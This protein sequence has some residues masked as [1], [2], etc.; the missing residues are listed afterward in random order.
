[1]RPEQ[2]RQPQPQ[3]KVAKGALIGAAAVLAVIYSAGRGGVA[4]NP[5][6]LAFG[7]RPVGDSTP[8]QQVL[9]QNTSP[10]PLRISSVTVDGANSGDFL[11]AQHDCIGAV[12]ESGNSCAIDVRFLPQ[13]SGDRNAMLVL[14]DN[15][16]DSP[17]TVRL[18]GSATDRR[19]LVLNP[20]ILDFADVY[21]G[22]NP[23][24]SVQVINKG[25]SAVRISSP[26][27][28]GDARDEFE[29]GDDTCAAAAVAAPGSARGFGRR[30][31]AAGDGP[32]AGRAPDAG[33]RRFFLY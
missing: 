8:A 24:K 29:I 30:A 31:G 17:Q 1:V 18:K 16:P 2:L 32:G 27:L 6:T 13:A 12:I 4:L 3:S 21:L 33:D 15:A 22:S 26:E 25:S 28:S 23:S 10:G 14:A 11:I 7:S 19:D 5:T 9:L 20:G